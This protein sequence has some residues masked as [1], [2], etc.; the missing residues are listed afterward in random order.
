MDRKGTTHM[1]YGSLFTTAATLGLLS[2]FG[3][4]AHG[5]LIQWDYAI[6][7]SGVARTQ[8]LGGNQAGIILS[9]SGPPGSVTG[10]MFLPTV[11]LSPFYSPF[12]TTN[13]VPLPFERPDSEFAFTLNLKDHTSG[14]SGDFRFSG[15]FT[16]SISPDATDA[17]ANFTSP[18]SSSLMLGHNRYTVALAGYASPPGPDIPIGPPAGEFDLFVDVQPPIKGAP[19]PSTLML[20][21]LGVSF[22]GTMAWR[23]QRRSRLRGRGGSS[24][25]IMRSMSVKAACFSRVRSNGVVPVSSS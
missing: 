18:A 20:G 12:P 17:Q 15:F 25:R 4:S 5:E 1:T 2:L 6:S 13:P 7:A 11:T 21:G 22:L 10:P 16:G 3:S 24:S 9:P 14:A 8:S 23:T 19:E